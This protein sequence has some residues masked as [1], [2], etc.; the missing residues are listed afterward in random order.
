MQDRPVLR[1]RAPNTRLAERRYV[2]DLVFGEWLG[3]DYDLEPGD[4]RLV[5]IH[6]A[7]DLQGRHIT[8]P[9]ALFDTREEDWLT[10]RSLPPTPLAYARNPGVLSASPPGADQKSP[11]LSGAPLPLLYGHLAPDGLVW[12]LTD[13]GA[14]FSMDLFGSVFFVLTRYEEAVLPDRDSRQRFPAGASLAAA[15][16]LLLRPIVDEYLEVLWGS[17]HRVWPTLPRRPSRFRFRLTHD[18]DQPWAARRS[19]SVLGDLIVRH[20]PVLAARRLRAFSDARA[21]RYDRDPFDTFELLMDISER[22]GL[23]SL[24]YFQAGSRDG[25]FDF[26]YGI[27]DSRIT[28]VLRRIHDRGHEV[29]L[30]SSYLSYRSAPRIRFELDALRSACREA[31]FDQPSWGIRQHYLRF[32]NPITWRCQD[33]AGLDH[34]STVGWV[35]QVGFRAGTG[36]EYPVFDLMERRQLRLRERPLLIMDGALFVSVAHDM[37][38]ARSAA[39]KIVTDCRRRN[40][41]AVVLF[42]N[43]TIGQTRQRRLYTDLVS[44]CMRGVDPELND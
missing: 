36:R 44:Q 9:D 39:L 16:G 24:F 12:R 25:D 34:D 17:L 31:G 38:A 14:E 27:S 8:F 22:H 41:D 35:E 13:A 10:I 33:Q 23:K 2:F 26:R 42:H 40:V 3:I 18:V 7:G 30:H 11:T 32:A 43:H 37:E 20:D 6:L 19:R 1:I 21:G 5:T 29:G 28:R 15:E 4:A